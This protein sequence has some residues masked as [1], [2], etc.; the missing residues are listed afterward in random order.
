MASIRKR[1]NGMWRAP[2]RDVSGKEHARHF[3]R[4]VDG[5]R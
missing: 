3:E 5:Q 1:D 4:K 2:Y